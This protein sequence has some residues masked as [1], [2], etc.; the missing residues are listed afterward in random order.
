[1]SA[2]VNHVSTQGDLKARPHA[3]DRGRAPR[4]GGELGIRVTKAPRDALCQARRQGFKNLKS[5]PGGCWPSA[6]APPVLVTS[7]PGAGTSFVRSAM[8]LQVERHLEAINVHTPFGVSC[9][10]FPTGTCTSQR[11]G[12]CWDPAERPSGA[13]RVRRRLPG[14]QHTS[15]PRDPHSRTEGFCRRPSNT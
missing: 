11:R 1:M 10:Y 2:S 12:V 4:G 13:V 3:R 7:Q 8:Y 6:P 14:G 9:E 5:S 15:T